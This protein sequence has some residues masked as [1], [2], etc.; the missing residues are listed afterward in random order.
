MIFDGYPYLS[1]RIVPALYHIALLPAGLPESTLV[2]AAQRQVLANRL[3]VCL[4]LAEDHAHYFDAEGNTHVSAEPPWG[5]AIVTDKLAAVM[6]CDGASHEVRAR[7]AR[8]ATVVAQCASGFLF[9]DLSKGGR[10]ATTRERARLSGT[11]RDGTPRG[12]RRCVTCGDW[13]GTCLNTLAPFAGQVM[14]VHCTCENHNRCV[15]CG[16]LLFERRL[17][18]NY[19]DPK[20]QPIWHVP[21]FCGLGHRC[22]EGVAA[23]DSSHLEVRPGMSRPPAMMSPSTS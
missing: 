8:L 21:G 20:D 14:T 9:G 17:N 6:D 11:R 2:E 3:P 10:A 4:V 5:G 1:T 15:R 19:Y 23:R 16:E 18:A 22:P 7:Q 13:K 12:L